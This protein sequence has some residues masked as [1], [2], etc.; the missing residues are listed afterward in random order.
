MHP[1]ALVPGRRENRSALWPPGPG[2]RPRWP[3][4]PGLA[5]PRPGVGAWGP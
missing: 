1:V 4:R 3:D 5:R 2:T